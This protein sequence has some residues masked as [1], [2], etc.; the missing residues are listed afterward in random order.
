MDGQVS[1][2]ELS[3]V[4]EDASPLC[5]AVLFSTEDVISRSLGCV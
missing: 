3:R 4:N 1:A 5:V 2:A